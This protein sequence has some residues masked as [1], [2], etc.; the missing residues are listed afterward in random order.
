MSTKP[1]IF[2]PYTTQ[3]NT[4]FFQDL[5]VLEKSLYRLLWIVH[6]PVEKTSLKVYISRL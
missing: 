6:F 4:T 5:A 3:A 1:G 2:H